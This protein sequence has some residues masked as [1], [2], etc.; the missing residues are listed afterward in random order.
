VTSILFTIGV[1]F[2]FIA[3]VNT[4]LFA[5]TPPQFPLTSGAQAIL[6]NQKNDIF[7][8][9]ECNIV[10]RRHKRDLTQRP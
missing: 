10:I 1:R 8:L 3:G 2:G 9:A 6:S 7:I 4:I 5:V